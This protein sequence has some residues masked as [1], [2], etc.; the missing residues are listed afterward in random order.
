MKLRYLADK[1]IGDCHRCPLARGRRSIVFGVGS[2]RARIVFV[3]EAPGG[4]ED[5]RGEPFV[6]PAG[7]R[8]DAWLDAVGL[9]RDD[10]YI[11]N[12]VKCRP[13]GNRDPRPSEVDAC[14]PFLRAQ[15]RAIEPRVIVALGRHAAMFMSGRD[16]M[17]LGRLRRM[18][19]AYRDPKMQG[20]TIP[21]VATYHP[22]FI[23]RKPEGAERDRFESG[24]LG[25]LRRAI[26]IAES[27]GREHP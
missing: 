13:P 2:A 22:A 8:L 20:R 5:L 15:L 9:A 1:V 24:V 14:A 18:Q 26:E 27:S 6:G 21:V 25:D 17:S 12:V 3:G 11:A 10:V 23:L 7:A 4:E 16:D 19:L